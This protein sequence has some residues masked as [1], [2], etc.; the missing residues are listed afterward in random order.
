M[1]R[2]E[3]KRDARDGPGDIVRKFRVASGRVMRREDERRAT[4]ARDARE[5]IGERFGNVRKVRDEFRVR[6]FG[7]SG[8]GRDG[9]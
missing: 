4:V 6:E 1:A 5:R 9:R 3:D 2:F 7:G 8:F